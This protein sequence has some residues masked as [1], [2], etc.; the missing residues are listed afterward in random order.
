MLKG[1]A[2]LDATALGLLLRVRGG[3]DIPAW[4]AQVVP[5]NVYRSGWVHCIAFGCEEL[6]AVEDREASE[7]TAYAGSTQEY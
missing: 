6:G 3:A 5:T 7:G 1:Q 2:W 4:V